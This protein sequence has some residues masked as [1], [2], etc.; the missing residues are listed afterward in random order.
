MAARKFHQIA[1]DLIELPRRHQAD[2]I[3]RQ[4]R[5][6]QQQVEIG[7]PAAETLE[8][9]VAK[10]IGVHGKAGGAGAGAI[11]Q[12]PLRRQDL[13][14]ILPFNPIRHG[15]TWIVGVELDAVAVN[16]KAAQAEELIGVERLAM[17]ETA[18]GFSARLWRRALHRAHHFFANGFNRIRVR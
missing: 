3:L 6:Q 4:V 18:H 7:P 14:R 1:G 15:E 9:R 5:P 8:Q 10:Q 16:G 17:P 13:R 11:A 2:F 12:H